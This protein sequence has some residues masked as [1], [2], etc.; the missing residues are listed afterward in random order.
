MASSPS[1]PS[2]DPK[3]QVSFF[4]RLRTVRGKYLREAMQNTVKGM[5]IVALDAQLAQF[6]SAESLNKVASFGLRGELFFAVPL[7]LRQNPLLLGYYRLLL[8]FSQKEFYK[9]G[10]SR[11]KIMEEAAQLPRQS[12]ALLDGLCRR[13]ADTA[14]LLVENL[15]DLSANIIH[16]LQLLT[17]GP[18]WRGGENTRI[19]QKATADVFDLIRR[20]VQPWTIAE[21]GRSIDLRNAAGRVVMIQFSSDPDIAI[22]EVLSNSTRP[23]VSIEIKG[24]S[25]VSNIH[26]RLGEA[27]KSHQNAKVRGFTEFW[28]LVRVNVA[29]DKVRAESPTTSRVYYLSKILEE[30]TPEHGVFVRDL[31]S[32]LGI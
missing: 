4:Y 9:V 6:V 26:N 7:V 1:F 17:I 12:E 25:D 19:G 5:D 31:S 30:N 22:E 16:E 10:F 28:T 13:L 14:S 23:I 21:T 2:L 15:D 18:Q 24:G 20:M 11:F 32:R 29:E 8:G 3:L 27:E